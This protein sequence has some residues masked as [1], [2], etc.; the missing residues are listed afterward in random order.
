MGRRG[1][2]GDGRLA[3]HTIFRPWGEDNTPQLN[4]YSHHVVICTFG[5]VS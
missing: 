3:S 1:R 2:E 4:D 5:H